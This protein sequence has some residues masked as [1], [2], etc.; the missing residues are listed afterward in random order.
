MDWTQT[1]P[2]LHGSR[3]R[4]GGASQSPQRQIIVRP[5]FL[6]FGVVS[7]LSAGR[8]EAFGGM[9][10]E[11]PPAL[12]AMWRR[13]AIAKW[14]LQG[15]AKS[16]TGEV[17]EHRMELDGRNKA[18]HEFKVRYDLDEA[19]CW[20]GADEAWEGAD[21]AGDCDRG[22]ELVSD[23]CT[24]TLLPLTQPAR[25]SRCKHLA[26]C[27]LEALAALRTRECPDC[28]VK[29]KK[30]ELVVDEPIRE[31]LSRARTAGKRVWPGPSAL[32]VNP[33]PPDST[34]TCRLHRRRPTP[35]R[36]PVRTSPRIVCPP[37]VAGKRV[38]RSPRGSFEDRAATPGGRGK[39]KV[40]MAVVD[41]LSDDEAGGAPPSA[42]RAR[43]AAG[44]AVQLSSPEGGSGSSGS[45]SSSGS[46]GSGSSGGGGSSSSNSG[47]GGGSVAAA[48]PALQQK[49]A[50]A[51]KA[52]AAEAAEAKAAAEKAAA[53]KAAAEKAAAE[54]AAAEKAAEKAA[55]AKAE[56][57]AWAAAGFSDGPWQELELH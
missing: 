45:G 48:S 50:A 4:R 22:W 34:C 3:K 7:A 37:C 10:G 35:S 8:G 42:K 31:A 38:W 6:P 15:Q 19:E 36:L 25:T 49:R 9:A 30:S 29:F 54:K 56:F 13:V 28:G 46:S 32:P 11:L 26:R 33:R 5:V 57:E 43:S 53:E 24:I 51:A 27:N 41:L 12:P 40:Q 18:V 2:Y 16:L 14:A 44:A 55:W 20:H 52:A 17:V 39:R 47:G 23:T 21:E 1:V